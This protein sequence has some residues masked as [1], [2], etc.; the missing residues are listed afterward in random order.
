VNRSVVNHHSPQANIAS[1][2]LTTKTE[3]S[4]L[5][6]K[7]SSSHYSSP[8]SN[9]YASPTPVQRTLPKLPTGSNNN[10][11]SS[12]R[13]VTNTTIFSETTQQ[14]PMVIHNDS[15]SIKSEDSSSFSEGHLH[16][17]QQQQ[18]SSIRTQDVKIRSQQQTTSLHIANNLA[19]PL[20]N[21]TSS[22]TGTTTASS[23]GIPIDRVP[24]PSPSLI[25]EREREENERLERE[26]ELKRKRLQI[27]VFVCRCVACPFNSKQS[28]DM[29]RKHLKITLVQYG[30]IKERFLAFLNGKTHI[31]ADEGSLFFYFENKKC[32]VF[33]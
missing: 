19:K 12:I 3:H 14:P 25:S 8:P 33:Y 18:Q 1:P 7:P 29:A 17:S 5:T 20:T 26:L 10:S 21:T 28:S 31:E 6:S 16:P 11:L 2:L 9:F 15:T 23:T 13:S 22:S 4:S 32:F 30:V 24:S 27:Y